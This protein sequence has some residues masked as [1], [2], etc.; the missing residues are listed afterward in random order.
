MAWRRAGGTMASETKS[1]EVERDDLE[2]LASQVSAME[3][4]DER[5]AGRPATQTMGEVRAQLQAEYSAAVSRLEGA[6]GLPLPPEAQLVGGEYSVA[7]YFPRLSNA[8]FLE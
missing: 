8:L 4:T 7:L 1:P 3:A 5:P 2:A 6:P